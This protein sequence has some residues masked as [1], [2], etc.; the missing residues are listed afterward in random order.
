MSGE[1]K[2]RL[3]EKKLLIA[4]GAWGT[5]LARRGLPAGEAP[6]RWNLERPDEVRA[7]AASYVEAG[8]DII[9]TN[10]F[11]GSPPKLARAGLKDSVIEVNGRGVELSRKVAS[12]RCLVF[13]SAGPTGEMIDPLGTVSEE[14]MIAWF[15]EQVKAIVAGGPDGIVI[16]TMNDL[17][18][19]K[20]AL[21]A[22]KENCSLPVV[23]SMTFEKGAKGFATIMGVRPEQAAAELDQAGADIVGANCGSGIQD[24]I[25][26]ARLMR[27]ATRLPLW[28][29]PNAGLPELVDGQTIFRQ[30]PEE[31]V[32]HLPALVEACAG[33]VGGCCGTTPAHIRLLVQRAKEIA[34]D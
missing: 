17:R 32:K 2:E 15:A 33:I 10:T 9:L 30:T 16:E 20:A 18:E 13:A 11:G 22:V 34:P 19:A 21:L 28:F 12:G 1:W 3:A 29:K 7:V 27:P 31:M 25:S 5:E 26:V 14:K 24:I 6:E 4:D 23:V 8:S